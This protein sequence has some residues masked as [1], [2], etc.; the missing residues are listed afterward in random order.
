MPSF[1]KKTRSQASAPA[2]ESLPGSASSGAPPDFYHQQHQLQ[3][4]QYIAEPDYPDDRL[5]RPSEPFIPANQFQGHSAH[6]SF[7]DLHYDEQQQQHSLQQQQQQQQQEQQLQQQQQQQLHTLPQ[8]YHPAH[9]DRPTISLVTHPNDPPSYQHSPSVADP[10][11]T[12][13]NTSS[14]D[15]EKSG[16]L[17][18]KK[19]FFSRNQSVASSNP[20]K[21]KK[22]DSSALGRSHSVKHNFSQAVP[23]QAQQQAQQQQQQQTEHGRVASVQSSLNLSLN[24]SQVALNGLNSGPETPRP[25]TGEQQL[26]PPSSPSV[27]DQDLPQ[28]PLDSQAQAFR[29][30]DWDAAHHAW[31]DGN[32]DSADSQM[33]SRRPSEIPDMANTDRII[34]QQIQ[35]PARKDSLVAPGSVG[36]PISQV[37]SPNLQ[38]APP[39]PLFKGNSSQQ[40]LHDMPA[41][42][43]E[44]PPAAPSKL[45]EELEGLDIA[46]LVLRH[47]ELQAKYQKVKRYYFEKEAQVTQL[48][49]TVAHQRMAVSRTVLDDNEYTARFNR[50]DG[51]IKELAFSIRKDWKTI[52]EWLHPCVNEDAVA[53]GTKEMTGVGRA[54]I[55]RWIVEAVFNRYFH[56]GLERSFS[57]R[58]KAIEMTLR[59]QQVAVFND[60]DKENQ[61]ARIS[62]WRRTT[63]DGLAD[64]LQ[65]K[66]TAENQAQLKEYL[67]EKLSATL[68][69]DLKEPAPPELAHYTQMIVENALNIAEKIP[70]E[71]RDIIVDYV[72]PGSPVSETIM[73]IDTGLPALTRPIGEYKE[74]SSSSAA[75]MADEM[76]MDSKESAA[77]GNSPIQPDSSSTTTNTTSTSTTNASNNRTS[78]PVPQNREQRKKYPFGSLMGKKSLVGSSSSSNNTAAPAASQSQAAAAAAAAAAAD[79]RSV[80]ASDNN[81]PKDRAG[82]EQ[83]QQQPDKRS[84]VRFATFLTVEVRGRGPNNVLIQAPVYTLDA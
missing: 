7:P 52:P 16:K 82:D 15:L 31:Q 65:S 64:E 20:G 69:F 80:S 11:W 30:Q 44:T 78:G 76:D 27:Y 70:Q 60:D 56:P 35:M 8:Q 39:G 34:Q 24:H 28:T 49:N 58:L 38:T 62:N 84:R 81:S 42:G 37:P 66:S 67:V 21:Q 73:K 83:Q 33:S 55:S 50:L 75:D 59:Q 10:P 57:E 74:F 51:A 2:G 19:G 68:Q 26:Q 36:Q 29:R 72:V 46:A 5:R 54:V 61:V 25:P 53:V 6:S 3:H 1:F 22:S 41:Q 77:S 9:S 12:H 71:S 14:Q 23:Q 32:Q 13:A 45:R 48:Q 17:Q 63:L 43:R 4:Q 79:Q 40:N 47:E 18:K